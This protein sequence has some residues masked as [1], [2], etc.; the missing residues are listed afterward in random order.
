MISGTRPLHVLFVCTHNS[1]RSV[2]AEALLNHLGHGRFV[3]FSAGSHPR[4]D[5]RPNPLAL[6]VLQEA[7]IAVEGL[8]SKSWDTFA[9]PDAPHM[10]LVITVCD[11]AAGE[12]CPL[13]PGG[14][15]VAHWGHADPS[16]GSAPDAVK[17]QAFRRTLFLLRRRLE[18]LVAEPPERL[19]PSQLVQT[20]RNLAKE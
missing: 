12:S 2:L 10:D 20:A 18:R 4:P 14:P 13:W 1:A 11:N 19:T 9:D 8:A 7:G 6:Q 16:A 15:A 17:L 3:A 5:Q